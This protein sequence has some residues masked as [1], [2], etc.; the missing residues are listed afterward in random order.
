MERKVKGRHG[1]TG[2]EESIRERMHKKSKV[3]EM[4]GRN[5]KTGAARKIRERKGKTSE[6]DI[7]KGKLIGMGGSSNKLGK[8]RKG[9]VRPA[10]EGLA[11]TRGKEG[12]GWASHHRLTKCTHPCS[13]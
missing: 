11:G 8:R 12:V 1:E 5:I 13:L 10:R 6:H 2:T 3:K 4:K 9:K 7:M